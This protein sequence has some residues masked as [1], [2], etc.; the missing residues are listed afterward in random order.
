M[1]CYF[2]KCFTVKKVS[3]KCKIRYK[4]FL[5]AM[6]VRDEDQ[7]CTST[8]DLTSNKF[9]QQPQKKKKNK[10]GPWWTLPQLKIIGL[11]SKIKSRLKPSK[12]IKLRFTKI[13]GG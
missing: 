6:S 10:D 8:D 2:L 13:K 7:T 1:I 12:N 9:E 3:L 4:R 5:L 11:L